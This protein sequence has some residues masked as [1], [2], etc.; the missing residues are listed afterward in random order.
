MILVTGGSG[1]VG[2]HLCDLLRERAYTRIMC[3]DLR[4]G[5]DVLDY[6]TLEKYV[7]DCEV[8]FDC[9]GVLGSAETFDHVWHTFET[10]VRGTLNILEAAHQMGKP[11]VHLSLKNAWRN[12]YMISKHTSTQLCE[13]YRDYHHRSVSVVRG[14]NAYGPRQHWGAV[15]KVVPTFVVNAIQNKALVLFGDGQQIV[16]LI[17]VRDLAE[18]MVRLWEQSRWGV[19]IDGGTGFPVTVKALAEAIIDLSGSESLICYEPMRLGEPPS[20]VA[21][22]DASEALRAVGYYPQTNL[23]DGLRETIAWYRKHWR[24]AYVE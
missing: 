19:V 16:D 17:H 21:I 3:Y 22:A 7:K 6:P 15:R 9:A 13:M 12:P 10:N 8:V 20:A 11:V 14:L 24:E 1:F 23:V 4:N 2:S 5:L 18:I